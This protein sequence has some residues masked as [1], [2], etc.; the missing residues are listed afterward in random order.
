MTP[1]TAASEVE[2][3]LLPLVTSTLEAAL[4][5]ITG[6]DAGRSRQQIAQLAAIAAVLSD[7]GGTLT[8]LAEA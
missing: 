7:A 8:L 3:R 6:A 2:D 4:M 5:L 1:G